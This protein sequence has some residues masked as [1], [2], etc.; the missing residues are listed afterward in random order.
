MKKLKTLSKKKKPHRRTQ[1]CGDYQRERVERL[2]RGRGINGD[3]KRLDLGW[4]THNA[5]YR[6]YII[7]L[8]T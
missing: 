6:W 2:K 4:R 1:E 8:Y 3:G 5:I 7:E